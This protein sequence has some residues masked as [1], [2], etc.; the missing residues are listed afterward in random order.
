MAAT[1]AAGVFDPVVTTGGKVQPAVNTSHNLVKLEGPGLFLGA[2]VVKNGGDSGLTFVTLHI[3]NRSVVDISYAAAQ[4]AGLAQQNPFG[5]VLLQNG[6]TRTLTCG[7]PTPLIYR[8]E[9]VL[10]VNVREANVLQINASVVH[11]ST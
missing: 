9:L 4:T 1:S 3:D 7:F 10:T 6:I 11:G 2:M 5:V 8:K